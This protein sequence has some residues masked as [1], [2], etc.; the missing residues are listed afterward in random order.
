MGPRPEVNAICQ[1]ADLADLVPLEMTTV[2]HL[3]LFPVMQPLM[4][5]A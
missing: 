2:L 3:T 1:I 4:W 5:L